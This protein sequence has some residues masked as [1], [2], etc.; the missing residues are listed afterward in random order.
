VSIPADKNKSYKGLYSSRAC[1]LTYPKHPPEPSGVNPVKPSY[2]VCP[3]CKGKKEIVL[4]T[5]TSPCDTCGGTRV[6][7]KEVPNIKCSGQPRTCPGPIKEALKVWEENFRDSLQAV[8][9]GDMVYLVDGVRVW[10]FISS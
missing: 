1:L 5:S 7:K 9:I 8:E 3:D 6:T 2:E 10:W 4:L